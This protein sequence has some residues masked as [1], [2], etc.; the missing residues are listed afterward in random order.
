MHHDTEDFQYGVDESY[1]L[2]I[3]RLPK[4]NEFRAFISADNCFGVVRA[5]E[6]FYQLIEIELS[7]SSD[8]TD[9]NAVEFEYWINCVPLVINDSPRFLWRY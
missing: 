7:Q 8:L 4:T 5:L 1:H 6:S 3:D 9:G 2:D